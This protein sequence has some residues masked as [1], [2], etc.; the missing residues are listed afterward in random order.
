VFEYRVLREIFGPKREE[1]TGSG[2]R[3][4][5]EE[6]HNL[7]ASTNIIRVIKPRKMKRVGHVAL[8]GDAR[9][10]Y[11]IFVGNLKGRDHSEGLIMVGNIR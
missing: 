10:A 8:V 9:N 1:L 11:S 7:C 2:R 6:L 3:L 5:N 4:H